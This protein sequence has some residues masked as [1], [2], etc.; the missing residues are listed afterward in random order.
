MHSVVLSTLE[1]V[2]TL[3]RNVRETICHNSNHGLQEHASARAR[4]NEVF[5][6]RYGRLRPF[7]AKFKKN[8][9]IVFGPGGSGKTLTIDAVLKMLLGENA[10]EFIRHDEVEETPAGYLVIEKDGKEFKL[11]EEKRARRADT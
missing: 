10:E 7:H 2:P 6:Q 5:I 8:I 4:I 1:G 3:P 9:C 11:G